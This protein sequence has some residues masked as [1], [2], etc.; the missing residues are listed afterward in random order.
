MNR[1]RQGFADS[2]V[3]FFVTRPVISYNNFDQLA[4]NLFDLLFLTL[5]I[6]YE[7]ERQGFHF[8]HLF[9]CDKT[10]YIIP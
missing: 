5:V 10:F 4:L 6:I 2:H 7:R 1:D 9:P 3:Y 8:S